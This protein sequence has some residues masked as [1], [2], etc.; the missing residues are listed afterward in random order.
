[1]KCNWSLILP[2]KRKSARKNR[3][4]QELIERKERLVEKQ[5]HYIFLSFL[6][7]IFKMTVVLYKMLV[8]KYNCMAIS[9]VET[10][11]SIIGR[12]QSPLP[13]LIPSPSP[14]SLPVLLLG[15]DTR[16]LLSLN[17]KTF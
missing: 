3:I 11:H 17:F 5:A 6:S 2:V 14:Q 8:L 1:M 16:K 13:S 12:T 10:F 9:N 7:N 4:K 15:N